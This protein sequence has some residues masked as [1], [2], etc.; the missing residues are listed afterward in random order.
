MRLEE[1]LDHLASNVLDDRS[2][3]VAGPPDSLWSDELLVR[4]LNE[5]QMIFCRKA[6]PIIDNTTAQC[7]QVA[8]TANI[9]T[10]PLDPSVMRV[11]SVVPNDTNIPLSWLN[12]DLIAPRPI[13][14]LPDYY[15]SAPIAMVEQAGRPG[16]YTTDDATRVLRIRPA[17]DAANVASIVRL[18]LRVARLPIVPLSV[19]SPQLS[20]EIPEE[21]HLDLADY[22]AGRALM[23]ANVDS[24]AKDEGRKFVEGF[25]Q[26]LRA[27]RNDRLIAQN[28]P[29][30]Y[31]F[32]GWAR[33]PRY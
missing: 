28:A 32:G 25:M 33:T 26:K 2:N 15:D 9:N 29:G 27:A 5:G 18:N 17:P 23:Q 20:P 21:Y 3:L 12:Y 11:L 10:Y 30:R 14:S 13:S 22:A 1:I 16:W 31:I 7:C 24:D 19:E 8:L 6:W 4:Y